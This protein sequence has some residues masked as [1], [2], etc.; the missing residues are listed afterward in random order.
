[1]SRFWGWR[2]VI[3]TLRGV[4]KLKTSFLCRDCGAVAPRWSGRCLECG[5][6]DTVEPFRTDAGADDDS[7]SAGVDGTPPSAAPMAE[8]SPLA[9]PRL[10]TGISE[11]DRTL[12][13]GLVPGSAVLVGGDPGIGKSTLLLQAFS[14]LAGAGERVL[15]A[16]SE[17]SAQQVKLRAQ[18]ILGENEG[19]VR[20]AN[21]FLL[22][23][24]SVARITNEARRVKATLLAVDSIQLVHRHDAD[25]LPGSMTQLRRCC[26]ELVQ[27]AKTTGTVVIIVGHVTKEGDL[28]GPKLL[29]HLVDVVL[30]F[31]GERHHAYRLVRAT[32]NRFGSTHEIGLFEMT[33]A[34]L[35]EVD[36]SALAAANATEPRPGT[37]VVPVM[38]GSRVL[39]AEIQALAAAGFLGSAKRKASGMDSGRLSMMIAVLE[40]HGGL[41]LADQDIYTSVAGGLRIVEPAADLALCLAIAGAHLSRALAP[42]TAIIGEV[43]LSGEIRPVRMLEQRVAEAVRRG[44]NTVLVPAGQVD[45]IKRRVGEVVAMRSIAHALELLSPVK[46]VN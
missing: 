9:V 26:L 4:S 16:S 33:G 27:F 10:P 30:S 31:E 5:A 43:G 25:A 46:R 34:G 42:G 38:A 15:Y 20:D 12:G 13:G 32:K 40:K 21:L 44:C 17:E 28:A 1:M 45:T 29:E 22:A 41:R 8:I 2:Q 6:W 7:P 36:E 37:A 23:E 24:S 19:A 39:L 11:F 14:A 18:R 3:S 35:I